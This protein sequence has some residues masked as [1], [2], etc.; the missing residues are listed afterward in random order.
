MATG[1]LPKS[2]VQLS[3]TQNVEGEDSL[4]VTE[5]D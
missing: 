3:N 2:T 5:R 4:S 1:L